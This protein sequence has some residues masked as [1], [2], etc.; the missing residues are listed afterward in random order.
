MKNLK[1]FGYVTKMID[2][3][4]LSSL[5]TKMSLVA[6]TDQYHMYSHGWAGSQA[7]EPHESHFKRD[8]IKFSLKKKNREGKKWV[9]NVQNS[10]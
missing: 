7:S 10:L 3:D 5:P 2:K 6:E 9:N 1:L 4:L 8:Y